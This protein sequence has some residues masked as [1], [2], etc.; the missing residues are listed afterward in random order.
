[1]AAD[2]SPS[3]DTTEIATER[4]RQAVASCSRLAREVDVNQLTHIHIDVTGRC[5]LACRHCF[6]YDGESRRL[7]ERPDPAAATIADWIAQA[8]E[9]GCQ[10]VTFSGGEPFIRQDML[11]LLDIG[12]IPKSILTNGSL[13]SA[14]VLAALNGHE[15]LEELRI[16]WDGWRGHEQL[17]G[18]ESLEAVMKLLELL[19]ERTE[20][21]YAINT[22]VSRAGAAELPAMYDYILDSG[23]YMWRI[24]LP[25]ERGRFVRHESDIAPE[26]S[27]T[28]RTL[29][30]IVLEHRNR[31]SDLSLQVF[32]FF[33]SE[34]FDDHFVRFDPSSHPC[35]YY[36]GSVT[37]HADGSVG[38]CPTLP[39]TFG[40]LEESSLSRILQGDAYTEFWNLRVDDI[41]PCRSCPHAA[42]CGGG[43]RADAV[44]AG[45]GISG[46]DLRSCRHMSFYEQFRQSWDSAPHS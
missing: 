19:D 30:K 3:R 27:E 26:L 22:T 24:D 43:C 36:R 40:N 17:R 41:P 32:G 31:E 6:Y 9:L 20:I 2:A 35:A 12:G 29:S 16:S 44:L 7:S 4:P 21:P 46:V 8:M 39:K 33:K 5:N 37:I 42:I 34:M 18:R 11:E 14:D 13:I 28:F 45:N 38:L 10:H 23:A 1:M 15:L 25:F